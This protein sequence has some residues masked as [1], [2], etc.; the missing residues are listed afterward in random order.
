M[1]IFK[2]FR[3]VKYEKKMGITIELY[4]N[5]SHIWGVIIH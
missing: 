1:S 5:F 3:H 4:G 2:K